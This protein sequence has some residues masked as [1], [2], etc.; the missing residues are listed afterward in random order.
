M[1]GE[2]YFAALDPAR[3]S[4]QA[5]T[6]PVIVVSRDAINRNSPVVICV[7]CSE[8]ANFRKIYPSQVFLP[9]GA[10]GLRLDSIAM[11]EQVRAIAADR[12]RTRIGKLDSDHMMQIEQCLRIALD[13]D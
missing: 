2:V 1:R 7:P 3:G 11:A 13:L 5:G 10:G 8:R 6:R 9:K 12:L 4:E